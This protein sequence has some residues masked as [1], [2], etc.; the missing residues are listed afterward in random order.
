MA[1]AMAARTREKEVH[2]MNTSEDIRIPSITDV[3]IA[4]NRISGQVRRT[5]LEHS[6]QLSKMCGAEV[7]LKLENQQ[8]A[9]SFKIRGA[10]NKMFSMSDEQREH[11]V[12]TASSGNHAQG[13]A[14]AASKLASRAV[15]CVPET[16]PE[17]KKSSVIAR[18]GRFVDLR[19][20]GRTYDDT[21]RV[22]LKIASDDGLTYVSA[23][24]DTEIAAGQGTLAVEI[25]L[26]VPDIDVIICPL[27]GGGLMTGVA[28]ASRALRPGVELWGTTARN[29]QSW[30]HAWDAGR[31]EPIEERDSI[32]EALGG[33]ASQKLYPFIRRT[34]NGI[35]DSTEDEIMESVAF[36]HGAHHQVIEGAP[37]TAVAALLFNKIDVRGKKVALVISGGNLDDSEAVEILERYSRHKRR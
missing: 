14:A 28:V 16:C 30:Q 22:A 5:P 23:Y 17:T 1:Q 31:V 8:I 6:H 3:L 37:G 15:I 4:R 24:E 11:G 25:M 13:L 9:N 7:Y 20:A 32:A 35:I 34:I 27:S 12:V 2:E 21:E 10:M 29:N 36:I 33:S 19:V 18:G 26:D